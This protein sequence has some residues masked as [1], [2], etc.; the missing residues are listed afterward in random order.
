MGRKEEFLVWYQYQYRYFI[1]YKTTI[2]NI[3]FSCLDI[4][5][6]L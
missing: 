1:H 4:D 5:R 3:D 2:R 6:N